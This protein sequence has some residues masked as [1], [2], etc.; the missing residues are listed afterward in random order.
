MSDGAYNTRMTTKRSG[1]TGVKKSR[2]RPKVNVAVEL[3]DM[4]HMMLVAMVNHTGKTQSQMIAEALMLLY[5]AMPREDD[6]PRGSAACTPIAAAVAGFDHVVASVPCTTEQAQAI[7]WAV[8][9]MTEVMCTKNYRASDLPRLSGSKRQIVHL[10][11]WKALKEFLRHLD[12]QKAGPAKRIA[13]AIRKA[14]MA[15]PEGR[16]ALSSGTEVGYAFAKDVGA[17]ECTREQADAIEWAIGDM[18]DSPT[19]RYALADIPHLTDGGS[20][21]Q[22]YLHLPSW[23]AVV[24]LLYR[25]EEKYETGQHNG[26]V[27]A[28]K[29]AAAAIRKC[30]KSSPEGRAALRLNW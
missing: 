29:R 10:P 28:G 11:T 6:L 24:D 19:G 5:V 26:T 27:I 23:R 13:A 12:G 14:A 17:I 25:L 7:D 16:E 18:R 9:F 21:E 3:T 8:E 22:R 1:G 20:G 2:Q 30:A 15:V 4:D